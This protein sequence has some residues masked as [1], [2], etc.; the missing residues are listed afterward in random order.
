MQ[1]TRLWV[2]QLTSGQLSHLTRMGIRPNL[3]CRIAFCL[4]LR[5]P[6]VPDPILYDDGQVREFNRSTLLGQWDILFVSLLKEYLRRNGL[7]PE[8]DL[9]GHFR[10]HICRGV[11]LLTARFSRLSDLGDIIRTAVPVEVLQE[12]RIHDEE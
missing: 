4:S 7:D 5:E 11:R 9:E 8:Q 3:L 1:F 6:D 2:G 10:A 12:E